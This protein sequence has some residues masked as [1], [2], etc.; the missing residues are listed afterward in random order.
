MIGAIAG[1]IIGSVYEQRGRRH[2]G[3]GYDGSFVR[4]RLNSM[5]QFG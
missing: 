3:A 5:G 1:D 4:K 2:P